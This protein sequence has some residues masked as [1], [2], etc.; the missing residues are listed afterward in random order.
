MRRGGEVGVADAEIDDIDSLAQFL[1]FHLVNTCE[2]VWWKV[3][4]ASCVHYQNIAPGSLF[5]FLLEAGGFLFAP[6]GPVTLIVPVRRGVVPRRAG[7][8]PPP[9]R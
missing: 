6:P 8:S 7:S 9:D 3:I 1:L 2:K 4:H 5:I